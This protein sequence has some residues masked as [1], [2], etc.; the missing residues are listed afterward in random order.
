MQ[1]AF[2]GKGWRFGKLLHWSC[3]LQRYSEEKGAN[4]LLVKS[5]ENNVHIMCLRSRIMPFCSKWVRFVKMDQDGNP[6]VHRHGQHGDDG[7]DG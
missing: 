6:F 4:K 3:K 1:K 7:R 2:R 5:D